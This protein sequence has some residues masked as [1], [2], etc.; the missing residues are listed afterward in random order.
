M[1]YSS[2][3]TGPKAWHVAV[4]L[5]LVVLVADIASIQML[6]NKTN[7]FAFAPA[8][9]PPP[10]AA[11]A[12]QTPTVPLPPDSA[13]K[14]TIPLPP[15]TKA[16]AIPCDSW[17]GKFGPGCKLDVMARLRVGGELKVFDLFVEERVV[18][19]DPIT[20]GSDV[21]MAWF[22]LTDKQ[23][24]ALE[25]AKARGCTITPKGRG[26]F[27][28]DEEKRTTTSTWS[29]SSSKTRRSRCR[30]HRPRPGD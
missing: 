18:A 28:T 12:G 26:Q 25:L 7:Q 5:G 1:S 3:G 29:S 16:V 8:P 13:P 2:P 24:K 14:F 11:D 15:G 22:A 10:P 17:Y 21:V 6:G 30:S 23:A 4:F 9:A 20:P 19:M 27:R